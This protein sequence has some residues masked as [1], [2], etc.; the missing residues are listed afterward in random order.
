LVIF[1]FT[2]QLPFLSVILYTGVLHQH[3]SGV[4]LMFSRLRRTYQVLTYSP[5]EDGP[6][7]VIVPEPEVSP[8]K[9]SKRLAGFL[10]I[11]VMGFG[12]WVIGVMA[13]ELGKVLE[14][15]WGK[16]PST[17]VVAVG[18]LGAF[19]FWLFHHIL[20]DLQGRFG[21]YLKASFKLSDRLAPY[22]G[23]RLEHTIRSWRG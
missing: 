1:M 14:P 5:P 2:V 3:P 19:L 17:S 11:C 8:S 7:T 18:A 9:I 10:E 21:Q 16:K 4:T 23:H 12:F 15:V 22:V 20:T 6:D 13:V